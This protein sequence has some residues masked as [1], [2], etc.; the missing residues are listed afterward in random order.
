MF[1]V[2]NTDDPEVAFFVFAYL[3][4]NPDAKSCYRASLDAIRSQAQ[5]RFTLLC[6]AGPVNMQLSRQKEMTKIFAR[7]IYN[8][9]HDPGLKQVLQKSYLKQQQQL[10]KQQFFRALEQ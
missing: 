8:P 6:F 2:K 3:Q 1:L 7:P 5:R 9:M 10:V 4:D